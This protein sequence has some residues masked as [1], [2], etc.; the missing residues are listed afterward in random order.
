MSGRF[1]PGA[2]VRVRDAWPERQGPVHLRTPHYLRG[3]PG[4]VLR[5]LGAFPNPEDLAFG[6]PAAAVPLYHVAFDPG[7]LWPD[8][9]RDG[10]L[11]VEVFE[12]WLEPRA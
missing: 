2:A 11:V 8:A 7:T 6:R 1:Q 3:R 4:R 5:S 9:A 12:H 10:D